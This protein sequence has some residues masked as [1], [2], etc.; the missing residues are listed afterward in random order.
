MGLD[1]LSVR[2]HRHNTSHPAARA[3]P[4]CEDERAARHRAE[5]LERPAPA[6]ELERPAPAAEPCKA[7]AAAAAALP[8]VLLAP[9][10]LE[11]QHVQAAIDRLSSGELV[12]LLGEL[13]LWRAA[14]RAG[15]HLH[16]F[17]IRGVCIAPG[18]EST[19]RLDVT[20]P[21]R[22][23]RLDFSADEGPRALELV[24]VGRISIG[25]R[26]AGEGGSLAQLNRCPLAR[27]VMQPGVG[28]SVWV[29][30]GSA[31]RV[32]LRGVIV[33]EILDRARSRAMRVPYGAQVSNELEPW[34]L[35]RFED[36]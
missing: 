26:I 13:E 22:L 7:C 35:E 19:L 8:P 18:A 15:T 25:A 5:Q 1:V 11:P 14:R 23:V 2:C 36:R 24:R 29:Q 32:T 27:L 20:E 17:E 9:D 28:G 4:H 34:E 33:C 3:C 10:A 16:R 21:A 31:S 6:A 12:Q 30:N